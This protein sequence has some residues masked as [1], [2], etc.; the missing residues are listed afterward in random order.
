MIMMPCDALTVVSHRQVICELVISISLGSACVMD[1]ACSSD[2]SR[3]CAVLL[4]PG[5][6]MIQQGEVRYEWTHGICAGATHVLPDGTPLER[7]P[8]VSVQLSD[9]DRRFFASELV[10]GRRLAGTAD[11]PLPPDVW[12][13]VWTAPCTPDVLPQPS[14]GRS[15]ASGAP[16]ISG[17]S[18]SSIAVPYSIALCDEVD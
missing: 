5:T 14:G 11:V 10:Q 2:A 17:C 12:D 1:F 7:G 18:T 15:E 9:F 6:V 3:R 13:T 4:E 8:R 16:T